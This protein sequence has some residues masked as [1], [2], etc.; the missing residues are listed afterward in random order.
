MVV[1]HLVYVSDTV[2]LGGTRGGR[3]GDD[4]DGDLLRHLSQ[5]LRSSMAHISTG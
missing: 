4:G 1:S 2:Q 3:S 5:R